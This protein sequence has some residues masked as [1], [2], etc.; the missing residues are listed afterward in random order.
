MP[1]F[2]CSLSKGGAH[3]QKVVVIFLPSRCADTFLMCS[4]MRFTGGGGEGCGS[5]RSL[6]RRAT[7]G[8][9]R[10]HC[11]YHGGFR[12]DCCRSVQGSRR[13]SFSDT[14]VVCQEVVALVGKWSAPDPDGQRT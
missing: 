1:F 10:R 2:M 4:G 9:A 6:C 5:I 8:R 13:T 11:G 7:G 14:G 3:A 12:W